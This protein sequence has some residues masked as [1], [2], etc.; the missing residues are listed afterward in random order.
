MEICEKGTAMQPLHAKSPLELDRAARDH[1]AACLAEIALAAGPAVMEVYASG[2]ETSR[3]SP[4]AAPSRSPTSGRRR[5][6]AIASPASCPRRPWSRR[7]GSPQAKGSR[8]LEGSCWS[9]HSTGRTIHQPQRRIHHQ[10]GARRV[11]PPGRRRGL[12]AGARATVVRRRARVRLRRPCWRVDARTGR[13]AS[14]A[15]RAPRRPACGHGE[16]VRMPTPRPRPFSAGSRSPSGARSVR[17]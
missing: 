4:T 7:R 3:L 16:P 17:R 2:R 8:S 13:L 6:S 12:C 5:S 1:I 10:C 11:R 14:D 15:R 9:I